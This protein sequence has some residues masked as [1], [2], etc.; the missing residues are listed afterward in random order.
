MNKVFNFKKDVADWIIAKNPLY[1]IFDWEIIEILFYN[2][3]GERVTLD[4]DIRLY[5]VK[6]RQLLYAECYNWY[7]QM[8][9]ID[10]FK[11][12]L[13]DFLKNDGTSKTISDSSNHS[14]TKSDPYNVDEA[15]YD[16]SSSTDGSNHNVSTTIKNDYN[17]RLDILNK[18]NEFMNINNVY[19]K[20][21]DK[22][23]VLYK[24]VVMDS[25]WGW[26]KSKC[27]VNNCG[28]DCLGINYP[29]LKDVSIIVEDELDKL[30]F[31]SDLN[32]E[33]TEET[34]D[35]NTVH[36]SAEIVEDKNA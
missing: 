9:G 34:S 28:G 36:I 14:K 16:S 21:L 33:V 27:C 19:D 13:T 32:V 5:S 26:T 29:T 2:R 8:Q 10:Y 4:N 6:M 7:S 25:Q 30:D 11:N 23:R 24:S 1:K 3:Y 17:S 15:I 18:I 31:I 12:N 20:M 22:I 35:P